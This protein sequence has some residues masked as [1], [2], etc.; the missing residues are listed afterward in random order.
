MAL[1]VRMDPA[2]SY[3]YMAADTVE[4]NPN[5]IDKKCY[6]TLVGMTVNEVEEYVCRRIQH[7]VEVNGK[8]EQPG[9]L[10]T[11][12]HM[13]FNEIIEGVMEIVKKTNWDQKAV[14][15]PGLIK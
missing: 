11:D 10:F 2:K 7:F 14:N 1:T 9:S 5:R 6:K 12:R 13:D 8:P 4:A 3:Q 15:V